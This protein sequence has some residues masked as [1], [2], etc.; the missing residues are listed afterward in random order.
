MDELWLVG[1]TLTTEQAEALTSIKKVERLKLQVKSYSQT[2][3]SLVLS[4][5]NREFWVNG[6]RLE[7]EAEEK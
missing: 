1:D 3:L 4:I 5:P 6:E 2:A 7:N